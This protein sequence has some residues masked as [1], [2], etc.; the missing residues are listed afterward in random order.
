MQANINHGSE[1]WSVCSR[2]QTA[3]A[4]SGPSGYERDGGLIGGTR[5]AAARLTDIRQDYP[6]CKEI[7]QQKRTRT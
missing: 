6:G 1:P 5:K 2:Q 3:S 7:L 4:L